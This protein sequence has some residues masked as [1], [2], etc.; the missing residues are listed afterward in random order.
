MKAVA[1]HMGGPPSVRADAVLSAL[2]R[3]LTAKTFV[4]RRFFD[5]RS[6]GLTYS[7]VE[8]YLHLF[9]TQILISSSRLFSR[10]KYSSSHKCAE[11]DAAFGNKEEATKT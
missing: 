6:T 7:L 1:N 4:V 10:L 9:R 8:G 11:S 3:R 5:R 2:S